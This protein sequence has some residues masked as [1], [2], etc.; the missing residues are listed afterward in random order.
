VQKGKN[1]PGPGT[2][3]PKV[4]IDKLGVYFLSKSPNSK[5]PKFFPVG[6]H[7]KARIGSSTPGPGSYDPKTEISKRGDY[8]ISNFHSTQCRTFGK[9]K[10]R[11]QSNMR[12]GTPG[13]GSY[14]IPSDFGFYDNTPSF[15]KNHSN[16]FDANGHH[17]YIISAST[18][19]TNHAQSTPINH[20]KRKASVPGV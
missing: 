15:S 1:V 11:T 19:P 3:K 13:P 14:R 7:S 8:F 20:P 12:A 6:N 16:S 4:E 5:A 2:Y 9:D 17:R 18:T 10:R